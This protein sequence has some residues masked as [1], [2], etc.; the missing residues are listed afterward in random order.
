MGITAGALVLTG[1][2]AQATEKADSCAAYTYVGTSTTI[3]DRFPGSADKDC[4]DLK[5]TVKLKVTGTDPW[6]LDRDKDGKGCEGT[7]LKP[8]NSGTSPEDVDKAMGEIGVPG[9]GPKDKLPVT[10]PELP[11][12]VGGGVA[13]IVVGGGLFMLR[14][15]Q[16]RFTA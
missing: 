11:L 8:V 2:P 6:R 13:A 5:G 15:R 1:A 12:V 10:G 16:V 4:P 9:T 3:C 7:A 14:R